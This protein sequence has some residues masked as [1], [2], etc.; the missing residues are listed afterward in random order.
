VL[1]A[2]NIKAM[3]METVSASETSENFYKITRRNIPEDSYL[4]IRRHESL[5]FRQSTSACVEHC[6]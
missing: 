5:K 6:A 2:L 1:T 3:M 4:H